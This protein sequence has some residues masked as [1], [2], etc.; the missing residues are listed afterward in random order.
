MQPSVYRPALS[1]SLGRVSLEVD[2]QG[3][4]FRAWGT[5]AYAR[6]DRRGPPAWGWH[7]EP[8]VLE[9]EAGRFRLTLSRPLPG[10][11]GA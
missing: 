6:V 11:Q 7:R 8:G 5:E 4:F 2:R 3:A 10:T 9:A 1:L